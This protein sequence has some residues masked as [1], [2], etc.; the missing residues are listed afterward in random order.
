MTPTIID[1]HTARVR[2]VAISHDSRWLASAGEE[3]TAHIIDLKHRE[4]PPRILRDDSIAAGIWSMAF[5]PQSS[6]LVIGVGGKAGALVLQ[7]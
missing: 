7:T 2:A 1:P 6:N 5:D 4:Q 3:G